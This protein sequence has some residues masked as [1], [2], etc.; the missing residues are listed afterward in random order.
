MSL[1]VDE[2]QLNSKSAHIPKFIHKC[3]NMNEWTSVVIKDFH[4]HFETFS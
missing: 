4:A 3:I 2:F 1:S